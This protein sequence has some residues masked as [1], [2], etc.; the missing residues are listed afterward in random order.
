MSDLPAHHPPTSLDIERL[1]QLHAFFT[2][3][4]FS[5]H[6]PSITFE[7]LGVPTG[8]I[9]GLV[10]NALW[11]NC[12]GSRHDNI[13]QA[14]FVPY[15]LLRIVAHVIGQKAAAHPQGQVSPDTIAAGKAIYET[16]MTAQT[17]RKALGARY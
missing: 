14:N 16:A 7:D 4:P 8:F 5:G 1:T 15:M 10:G 13:P 11:E 17:A 6:V 12:W 2:A 9:H 3:S